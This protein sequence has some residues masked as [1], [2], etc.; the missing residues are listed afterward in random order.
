LSF[1]LKTC[2]ALYLCANGF[3]HFR[4][5]LVFMHSYHCGRNL[6]IYVIVVNRSSNLSWMISEWFCW[7]W[8]MH[9]LVSIYLPTL[10]FCFAKKSSPNVNLQMKRDI[11]LQKPVAH[12]SIWLGKR[13]SDLILKWMFIQKAKGLFIKVK[14]QISLSQWEVID[15]KDQK[16]Q[17]L[18]LKVES[19]VKLQI[20]LSSFVG[21]H[22]YIFL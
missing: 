3:V 15:S 22:I 18:W 20:M 8:D 7:S 5:L 13:V 9:R 17:M 16:D 19:N 12:S 2:F 21:G 6:E 1:C 4:A 10:Y 11:E 14:Y